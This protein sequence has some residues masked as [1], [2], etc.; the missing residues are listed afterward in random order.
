MKVWNMYLAIIGTWILSEVV[1]GKFKE[2]RLHFPKT[3][4]NFYQHCYEFDK[5]LT[6][7]WVFRYL[8]IVWI[9]DHLFL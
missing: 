1:L 3:T 9:N 6:N 5:F 2:Q 7:V 4:F 8:Y